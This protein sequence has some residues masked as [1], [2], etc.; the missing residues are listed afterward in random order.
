MKA[1]RK[2]WLNRRVANA[3][4]ATQKR[5][6]WDSVFL[7]KAKLWLSEANLIAGEKKNNV[8]D[9]IDALIAA[10]HICPGCKYLDGSC[11]FGLDEGVDKVVHC[12]E[13]ETTTGG[14]E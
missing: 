5:D 14:N 6:V 7:A 11:L 8:E 10:E 1:L 12:A 13:F 4:I 3:V 2:W 9:K